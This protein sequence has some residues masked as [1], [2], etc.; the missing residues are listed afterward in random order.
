MTTLILIIGALIVFAGVVILVNPDLIFGYIQNNQGNLGIYIAAI[1]VRLV[2]G[3][4]L[5]TQSKLSGFPITIEALGWLSIGAAACFAI[6]GHRNFR[7][8]LSWMLMKFTR[9]RQVGGI[10]GAI[11]GGFL[12]YAYV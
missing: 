1:V 11:F 10:I 8:L 7:R 4:L 12:I 2:I 6:M 3:A 5:V 9:F